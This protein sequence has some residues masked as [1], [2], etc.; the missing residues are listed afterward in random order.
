MALRGGR[1]SCGGLRSRGSGGR[2]GER[3]GGVRGALAWLVGCVGVVWVCAGDVPNGRSE[4][5]LPGGWVAQGGGAWVAL[6]WLQDLFGSKCT[7]SQK[8]DATCR[9]GGGAFVPRGVQ[10]ACGW[11]NFYLEN[12]SGQEFVLREIQKPLM[13]CEGRVFGA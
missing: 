10:D 8:A 6:S 5:C 7:T 4:R 3:V 12:F 13:S 11:L 9:G 2:R 1:G